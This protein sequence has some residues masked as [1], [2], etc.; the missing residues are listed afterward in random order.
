MSAVLGVWLGKMAF[1]Y[2]KAYYEIDL[3][4]MNVMYILDASVHV[5]FPLLCVSFQGNF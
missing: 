4:I 2:M 3:L 1:I 5:C